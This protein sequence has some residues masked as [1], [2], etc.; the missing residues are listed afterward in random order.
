MDLKINKK[1]LG[2]G[3]S[4]LM[5][6]VSDEQTESLSSTETKIPIYLLKN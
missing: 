6:E 2:R 5:G 1:G 3:L 4:S